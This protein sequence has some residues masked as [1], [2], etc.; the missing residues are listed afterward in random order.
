MAI[1]T[2]PNIP[3]AKLR[4]MNGWYRLRVDVLDNNT[5][6]LGYS[7]DDLTG[8]IGGFLAGIPVDK[9]HPFS[10]WVSGEVWWVGSVNNVIV[11]VVVWPS[12]VSSI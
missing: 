4:L 10:D 8:S 12:S 2:V 9:A 6:F 3:R 5:I 11:N 7:H 1:D